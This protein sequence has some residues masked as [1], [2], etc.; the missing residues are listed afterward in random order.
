MNPK[1]GKR[2]KPSREWH[3]FMN[4]SLP[5]IYKKDMTQPLSTV[6]GYGYDTQDNQATVTDPNGNITQYYND[7][8]GR[9]NQTGSPDTGATDYLYDEAGNLIQRFD[10]KETVVNYTY[11]AL[12]RL[13]AIQFSSDP[14]QNVTFTYDS[15]S[16]TYGIGRLTGRADPSG[17]YTFYYDAHG[18]LTREEKTI[19]S[20]LYTTQYT[21]NNNNILTSI[22]YPSGRVITYTPDQVGRISQVSTTLGGQPKTLASAI[23]YLPYGGITGL[24][25]GNG[26]SLNQGYDNQYRISSVVTGSILN[27]T[28]GYDPNGNI[29]SIA[30]SINP[31]GGQPLEIPGTYSYQTGTNKLIHIEGTPSIDFGYDLNGNITSET[32]WTHVYD[33]SNQLYRAYQGTTLMGEY[34]YNGAGQRIKKVTQTETRIFHYDLQGHLIAETN[35]SGQMLAEY[36]YLGDQLLAMIR[37]GENAYY[38][39]NDHLGTPQVLTDATGSIAWKASYDP[40]GEAAISI[41]AVENPFRF[42]G[43][44]YDPE[45]G[46]HYNYFRYYNPQTG[47]YITPDPIGLDGGIN[48][49]GYVGGNPVSWIDPLGLSFLIF[50]RGAGIGRI[51]VFSGGESGREPPV[52]LFDF[53]AGNIPDSTSKGPWPEGTFPF[54][55]HKA[56]PESCEKGPY[57]SHG[58]F[59]F[60][61]PG[62]PNMG[63]HSGRANKG[64]PCHPTFGCIR[65]I[66]EAM[67]A[68]YYLHFGGDPLTQ[69]TV[70]ENRR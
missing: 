3:D 33:L 13:T 22:T 28:Y 54:L 52:L 70:I 21:Y 23:T 2:N 36:I 47:R 32:G 45:T 6:T 40:F 4:S 38:F 48:L 44:Y 63:L 55:R 53:P 5:T 30:D 43:Q 61:V 69:I 31:P 50:I 14:N 26:L 64:G 68:I 27:L 49:F 67:S 39:H 57:G 20:I 11:D 18:N 58:I 1:G 41:Q 35:Q 8:F 56:H 62:R 15:T 42:P 37:P 17:T 25:Y 66:E 24:A 7:D 10:A 12:N 19:N 60:D 29:T 59:I 51:L 16:V 46:L 9:K 34:T 65:T